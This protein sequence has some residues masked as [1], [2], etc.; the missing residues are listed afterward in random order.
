MALHLNNIII[1]YKTHYKHLYNTVF[2]YNKYSFD[3][4]W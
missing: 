4:P 3:Y 1:L 2:N